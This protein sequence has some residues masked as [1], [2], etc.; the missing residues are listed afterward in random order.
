MQ[1]TQGKETGRHQ[2][3]WTIAISTSLGTCR[4]PVI[5]DKLRPRL[6][7]TFTLYSMITRSVYR[8]VSGTL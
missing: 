7:W 3:T 5:T 6:L 1:N 8:Q 2:K 4:K